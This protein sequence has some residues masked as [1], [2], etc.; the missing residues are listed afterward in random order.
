M[1]RIKQN[2]KISQLF[3]AH[4]RLYARALPADSDKLRATSGSLTYRKLI[5]FSRSSSLLASIV[6]LAGKFSWKHEIRSVTHGASSQIQGHRSAHQT[7]RSADPFLFAM[8]GEKEP[9]QKEQ[10]ARKRKSGTAEGKRKKFKREVGAG[11]QQ[12]TGGFSDE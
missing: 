9:E 6:A 5:S 12:E 4:R 3:E 1:K 8:A 7:P 10:T 11:R 2:K